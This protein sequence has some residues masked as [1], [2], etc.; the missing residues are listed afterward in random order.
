F[1]RSLPLF[2]SQRILWP[3]VAAELSRPPRVLAV[4]PRDEIRLLRTVLLAPGLSLREIERIEAELEADGRYSAIVDTIGGFASYPAIVRDTRSY[5]STVETIAHEWLHHYLF[6][7]PLGRAFFN[8][9]ELRSINETVADTIDEE[10]A[11]QVFATY[12]DVRVPRA[13]RPDRSEADALLV[14]LRRDVDALLAE[15]RVQE[16]ERL[17]EEVRLELA[18]KGRRFRRINLAFFAFNGVYAT[19]PAGATNPI[20]PLVRELRAGS[21]SLLDFV[22]AVREVDSL[23]ELQAL[24]PPPR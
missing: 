4:S 12:P 1:S 11:A 8:S 15:G 22:E 24:A 16:A 20:G 13:P 7:Y 14:Q 17:M 9:T 6:F 10:I 23:A 21:P 5:V 2:G 19:R 18:S 3:P